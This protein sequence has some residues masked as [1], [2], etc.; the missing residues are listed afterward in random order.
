MSQIKVNEI[1]DA[2]GGSAAKLYGPSMRYGGTAFVNRIINGDMTIAQRGTSFVAATNGTFGVDRFRLEVNSD[3][4]L[5]VSQQSDTPANSGFQYSLRYAVTTADTSIASGQLVGASHRIEGYNVRDLVGCTFTLSFWVRSSKTGVHCVSFRNSGNDR[6]YVAEYTVA[7]ANTWEQKFVTVVGGLITA[8]TWN[9][10][11][12]L[13]LAVDWALAT[14]SSLQTSAGAWQTGNFR[15]TS[16]QVNCLDT[17]GNIFAITGVQLEAGTVAS[18]FERRPYGT[19]LALCQRYYQRYSYDFKG[20]PTLVRITASINEYDGSM[21]IPTMRAS[22][23]FTTT[24][25]QVHKPGVRSES[26]TTGV[27][28]SPTFIAL[29]ITP[30]T[31]DSTSYAAFL[32]DG[33]IALTA[34]L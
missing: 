4:V 11:D 23:T 16:N 29:D 8:G 32:R 30:A 21:P 26:F 27:Y 24:S 17:V 2:S 6:T 1:Y 14:G 33:S 13:G 3:A 34:E 18:P 20:V 7:A 28:T 19:E 22:P 9:F 25:T 15:A 12:G 10:T 31:N 5:T